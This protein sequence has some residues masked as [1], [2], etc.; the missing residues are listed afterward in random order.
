MAVSQ[1]APV[2]QYGGLG[3]QLFEF[4][5]TALGLYLFGRIILEPGI[6][7]V[8]AR[9]RLNETFEQALGKVVHVLVIGGALTGGIAAA[10]FR[11]AFVGSA[12]VAA[13]VTL[14]IGFAARDVLSNFVAGVFII[15]DPKLNVG[16]TITVDG[17]TGTIRDIG[18]RVTRVRT[19]DNETVLIPNTQLV[20]LTIRNQTVNDPVS[21]SYEF[22]IDYDE[23]VEATIDLLRAI[24]AENDVILDTP[25]PTIRV[26]DLADTSVI[27]TA[28][29]WL[30]KEDRRRLPEIR[31]AY[32]TAVHQRCLAHG[33]DLSTTS[34]HALSGALTVDE[35]ALGMA[36]TAESA[37][38]EQGT[39]GGENEGFWRRGDDESTWY[40]DDESRRGEDDDSR[41]VE[42]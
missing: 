7:W 41:L 27:I 16:D 37:T 22:G 36:R 8:L 19:P 6:R 9:S 12:I 40:E 11:T 17:V 42:P 18:F 2:D 38:A 4:T 10:G 25:A 24:A 29:V 3:I 15:Q 28:R 26:T 21:I 32:L 35:P 30:H 13:G 20:T 14:A 23:D 33:I 1:L 5:V 39:N 31:S 34:Q